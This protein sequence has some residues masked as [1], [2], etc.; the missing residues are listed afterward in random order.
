M[1]GLIVK[2]GDQVE[3]EKLGSDRGQH[4]DRIL[5]RDRDKDTDTTGSEG[6]G[7]RG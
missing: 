2:V 5:G 7:F 4:I 1:V 6:I 3:L